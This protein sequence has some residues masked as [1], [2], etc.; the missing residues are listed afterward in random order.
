MNNRGKLQNKARSH[1]EVKDRKEVGGRRGGME[2]TLLHTAAKGQLRPK[3]SCL[4]SGARECGKVACLCSWPL[5]RDREG[6]SPS[7]TCGVL[8]L[9]GLTIFF[10]AIKIFYLACLQS[11]N[12]DDQEITV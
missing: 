12:W 4:L 11:K 2:Q 7:F 1:Y 8:L 3:R 5:L 9:L 6:L 10:S